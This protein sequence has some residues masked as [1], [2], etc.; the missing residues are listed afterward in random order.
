MGL[1]LLQLKPCHSQLRLAPPPTPHPP[2]TPLHPQVPIFDILRKFDGATVNEDI[3]LGEG[4]WAARKWSPVVSTM[5][6]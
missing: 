2:P 4:A 5:A 6:A 1:S 3:K